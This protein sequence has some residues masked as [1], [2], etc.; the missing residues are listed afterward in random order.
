MRRRM[1]PDVAS[2][3]F[4]SLESCSTSFDV[5]PASLLRGEPCPDVKFQTTKTGGSPG[6]PGIPIAVRVGEGMKMAAVAGGRRTLS[7]IP[8]LTAAERRHGPRG[9]C[10]ARRMPQDMVAAAAKA[11]KGCSRA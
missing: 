9:V 5:N 8:T 10:L 7:L 2:T 4:S 3:L 6:T 1:S 11:G